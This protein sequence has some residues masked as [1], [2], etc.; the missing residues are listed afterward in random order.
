[1]TI[2]SP[3]DVAQ[4]ML[5]IADAGH[6]YAEELRDAARRLIK[7]VDDCFDEEKT[8]VDFRHVLGAWAR[9]RKLYSDVMQED[10]SHE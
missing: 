5:E 1:M 7:A 6:V 2:G 9:C 4:K 10:T 3:K 8:E